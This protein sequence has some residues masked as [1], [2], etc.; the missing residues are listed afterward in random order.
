MAQKETIKARTAMVGGVVYMTPGSNSDMFADLVNTCVSGDQCAPAHSVS[1]CYGRSC[2]LSIPITD[3]PTKI[4]P[5]PMA[6]MN[7]ATAIRKSTGANTYANAKGTCE[8]L[9]IATTSKL[10]GENSVTVIQPLWYSYPVGAESVPAPVFP[11]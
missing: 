8:L 10:P 1:L 5:V 3:T 2:Y 6:I 7:V 11:C 9:H 4:T